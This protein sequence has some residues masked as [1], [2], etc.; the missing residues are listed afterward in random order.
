MSSVVT[1]RHSVAV[2][3]VAGCLS[4]GGV[5]LL[6]TDTVYGLA[7]LPTAAEAVGRIFALKGRPPS[8]NLPILI[9]DRAEVS[10]LGG[11]VSP[12]AARLLASSH[13]PGPLTVAVGIDDAAAPAWLAGRDEAA[14]RI[15][16]DEWLLE[17]LRVTGPVLATSANIHAVPPKESMAEILGDLAGQPD[18]VVDGGIRATVAS[19]LVNCHVDPPVIERVGAVPAADIEAVLA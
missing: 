7:A 4:A 15:P 6:P 14:F 19:T 9:S 3:E 17:V 2:G 18:L 12:A 10:R 5:V 16:A 13:V 11:I 8:I 1:R